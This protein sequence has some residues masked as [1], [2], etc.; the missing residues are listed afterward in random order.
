MKQYLHH[1][2][3][4]DDPELVS[5]IDEVPLWAAPFGFDLLETVVLR[6]DIR[7]LDVGCGLGF[8]LLELAFRLGSS[9]RVVGLDPWERALDRVR[10]KKRVLDIGNVEVVKGVAEDMPFDNAVFDLVVSNNGINNVRDVHSSLAEC[11]R[12][13]KPGAQFVLTFNTQET[14]REFYDMFEQTLRESG[15]VAEIARMKE[16]I[17]AKRKPVSEVES[18]LRTSGFGCIRLRTG[19]FALKFLDGTT[20][21]S[22]YLIKYWFLGGWKEV[23]AREDRERIFDRVEAELNII[24]RGKG[25]LSL[26]VPYVTIDCRRE[27]GDR[28]L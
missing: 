22:H 23:V 8:P 18:L 26:T 1:E 3:S 15:H 13:S 4:A 12:V 28:F 6:P 27:R 11:A 19:E 20:M 24:A 10:L 17:Y 2:F 9:S 16:H 21:F 7:A 14:M 5:V 25:C